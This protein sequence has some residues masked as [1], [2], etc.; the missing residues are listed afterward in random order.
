MLK[1]LL[2]IQ[3]VPEVIHEQ[4]FKNIVV[5]TSEFETTPAYTP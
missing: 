1:Q 3:S 4:Q 5:K 2:N